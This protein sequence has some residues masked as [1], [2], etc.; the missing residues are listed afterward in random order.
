M[1]KELPMIFRAIQFAAKA[2]AGHYR[3]VTRIPYINHPLAVARIITEFGF[4]EE[5][6]AVAAVL[7]DTVEDSATTVN[8]LRNQFGCEIAS[9]VDAVSVERRCESWRERKAKLLRYLEAARLEVLIL[10]CADK[11]DNL[12]SLR[13]D[14]QRLGHTVWDAFNAERNDQFWYYSSLSVLYQRRLVDA[15]E[16][17]L[18]AAFQEEMRRVFDW[19]TGN[20]KNEV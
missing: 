15:R 6:L 20:A 7:H 5:P 1:Q 12:R 3:K 13:S 10:S 8:Q 17:A 9:L 16:G 19:E 11:L 4:E 18:G 2:H 14:L